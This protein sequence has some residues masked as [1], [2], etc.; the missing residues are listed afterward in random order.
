M[1]CNI[2][3]KAIQQINVLLEYYYLDDKKNWFDSSLR[4][5][6]KIVSYLIVL[7]C[8]IHQ[9]PKNKKILSCKINK[10]YPLLTSVSGLNSY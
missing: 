9:E 8:K 1:T 2:F 4:F 3:C 7:F 6:F 10:F 5:L